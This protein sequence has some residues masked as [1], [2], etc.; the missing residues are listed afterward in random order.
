MSHRI[1]ANHKW[2]QG[3]CYGQLEQP[4][5][6]FMEPLFTG[7]DLWTTYKYIR[8]HE[9]HLKADVMDYLE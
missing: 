9:L 7:I 3:G 6:Y 2:R 4:L 8:Y 1:I 5:Q